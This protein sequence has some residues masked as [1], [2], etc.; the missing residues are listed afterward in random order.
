MTK[1]NADSFRLALLSEFAKSTKA[2]MKSITVVSSDL[3][4]YV[5]GYPGTDHRMPLCCSVMRKEMTERD[6]VIS[7]PTKGAGATLTIKYCLPR[8]QN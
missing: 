3:H 4:R 1:P 5:G 8:H 7:Q 2:G 6:E